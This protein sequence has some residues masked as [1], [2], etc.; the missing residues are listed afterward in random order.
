MSKRAWRV[1]GW[2]AGL[3]LLAYLFTS[4]VCHYSRL[5]G[6]LATVPGYDDVVYLYSGYDLATAWHQLGF[7]GWADHY[8]RIASHA[9]YSELL[10]AFTFYLF[11]FKIR[12]AYIANVL[13]VIVFL[14]FLRYFFRPLAGYVQFLLFG[15]FLALPFATMMVAEFRPDMAWAT[16][17]GF[18]MIYQV[19]RR[20]FFA[21]LGPAAV[22]GLLS[23]L[24][25]LAK[26]STFAMTI[27]MC[28]LAFGARFV[29]E[30]YRPN[31]PR[32]LPH[33]AQAALRLLIIIVLAVL[34]SLPFAYYFGRF[35]WEYFIFG[36][37]GTGR[38]VFDA[39]AHHPW[40][41]Y[42]Y[43]PAYDSNLAWAGDLL[44]VTTV[45]VLYLAR[46]TIT[47]YEKTE[48]ELCLILIMVPY[49]INNQAPIA[50]PFLAGA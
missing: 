21:T 30:F 14:A 43:G 16:F 47:R 24:T 29:L 35:I 41:Y 37:F 5:H 50:S 25:L 22:A 45:V 12:S 4:Q 18:T 3:V 20:D 6:R 49:V 39:F 31:P 10:A 27:L 44:L 48:F 26:P 8:G 7:A 34:V 17:L 9:P 2:W 36:V 33:L 11:G 40:N 46:R 23:G 1:A 19:T 13:L 28:L 32:F 38:Q 42:I 15:C